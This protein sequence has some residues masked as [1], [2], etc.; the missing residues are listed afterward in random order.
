V[1]FFVSVL[2]EIKNTN[3]R[4]ILMPL[5]ETPAPWAAGKAKQKE[6]NQGQVLVAP[7]AV[8]YMEHTPSTF[9]IAWHENAVFCRVFNFNICKGAKP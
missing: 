3:N 2:F 5:K 4:T 6:V 7:D 1:V 9:V 8:F